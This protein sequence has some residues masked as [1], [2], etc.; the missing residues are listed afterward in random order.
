MLLLCTKNSGTKIPDFSSVSPNTCNTIQARV[1]YNLRK[2]DC[3]PVDSRSCSEHQTV[4][5]KQTAKQ[6]EAESPAPC[7]SRDLPLFLRPGT[8]RK[9]PRCRRIKSGFRS[10]RCRS[11]W[12]RRGNRLGHWRGDGLCH[13]LC[14]RLLGCFL[15]SCRFLFGCL[16]RGFLG[17]LFLCGFLLSSFFLCRLLFGGFFLCRFLFGGFFLCR[18]LFRRFLLGW[19][20]LGWLSLCRDLLLRG[21]SPR[22]Y[23]LR[24]RSP[25]CFF[26]CFFL[27]RHFKSPSQKLH[28]TTAKSPD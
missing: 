12:N 5:W 4:R 11:R 2:P 27:C 20:S 16:P 21:G 9:R 19:L 18:F 8:R 17:G 28:S 6:P 23:L 25:R 26:R 14:C 13:R 7:C 24:S 22:R 10:G 1:K 15:L 3:I